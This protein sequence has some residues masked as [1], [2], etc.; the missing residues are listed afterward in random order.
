MSAVDDLGSGAQLVVL[1]ITGSAEG[2]TAAGFA[3]DVNTVVI[4]PTLVRLHPAPPSCDSGIVGWSLAG[5]NLPAGPSTLDGLPTTSVDPGRPVP[6]ESATAPHPN[7]VASI[8]H[9]VVSSPDLERTITAFEAVGLG[10]RRIRET[11]ASGRPMRQ[12][13]FR[14]GSTIVEVVS[15]ATGSGAPAETAPST[16]FGLAL[17]VADLDV[18]ATLLGDGLG[19]IK[20]AVQP[21]RRIAT[22][23]HRQLGLSV[24]VALMDDYGD[25]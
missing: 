20:D 16:W 21:G 24:P 2:W 3:V 6:A 10:C 13:F 15:G 7:G 4:G 9:V 5:L 19:R 22:V 14:L 23:R 12:A 1:D 25:R 11:E 18:T 17:N 8:D